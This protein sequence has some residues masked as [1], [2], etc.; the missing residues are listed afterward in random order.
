V[1]TPEM[2]NTLI[3]MQGIFAG[4]I[5]D[6]TRSY[7][8][9]KN[10]GNNGSAAP[11]GAQGPEFMEDFKFWLEDHLPTWDSRESMRDADERLPKL[12]LEG[13][14]SD[15][16]KPYMASS[17]KES[18]GEYNAFVTWLNDL[19]PK[20]SM[21]EIEIPTTY[22]VWGRGYA[23]RIDQDST[24][25]HE[26]YD[27]TIG[28]GTIGLDKRFNNLLI[29]LGGGY[30]HTDL[31]GGGKGNDGTADTGY[32][33]VYAAI[34]GEV[35]YLEANVNYAFNDVETEGI[36]DMGYEADYDASTFSMFI[37]GG[38]GFSTMN[39]SLL[40]SPE[41]SLLS[42]YYDRDSYTEKSSVEGMP[43]KKWG[44]YDQWSYLSSLGATLSMIK[45]IESFN[46][47]MEFQPE[48]RVHWL[49]EFNHEMDDEN[50]RLVNSASDLNA[51]LQSREEDLIQIGTG[52]RFSKWHS[53]EFEFGLDLD[54]AFGEDYKAYMISGKLLHRF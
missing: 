34:N 42:T 17:T 2:A 8:R 6:R 31:N 51:T 16:D 11:Q 15:V 23:S 32:G 21:D 4:Q 35:G 13:S 36:D 24:S 27:A 54:G 1:R 7:L 38:L 5:K 40:F 37:G 26:G 33:T 9:Y 12:N 45:Q 22:Q 30:A 43:D 50:Y 28:G 39:D 20:P 49:H 14:P 19:F 46:T 48:V 47:E 18:T 41:V 44:S 53:N 10:W 25:G 29:G 52:I 3:Q